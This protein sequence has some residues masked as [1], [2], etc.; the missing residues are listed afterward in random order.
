M[1]YIY[2]K[3]TPPKHFYILDI[4]RG[5]AA[6]S[7]VLWHWQHFYFIKTELANGFLTQ[8]QPLYHLF[9]VFYRDGL[10]AVDFFFSLSGFI[11]FYLYQNKISEQ[12]ITTRNFAIL[13]FSRLYPLHF[14]TLIIVMILQNYA[15]THTGHYHVY[16]YNDSYHFILNL[17][18][19]QTWGFE[20][21]NSFNSPS[22]SVSIEVFLYCLFFLLCRF[23]LI[24]K[25][26]VWLLILAGYILYFYIDPISRGIFS[27]FLGGAVYY[28]YL[29]LLNKKSIKSYFRILAAI[30]ILSVIVIPLEIH[31]GF[32]ENFSLNF[33]HLF[34]INDKVDHYLYRGII[35]YL[36]PFLVKGF[37]FPAVILFLALFETLKG[38]FGKRL[39]F[40]GHISFSAYL[41]HFPL[42][43]LL[44]V[45]CDQYK[46]NQRVLADSPITLL[47]F[48]LVLIGISL[49]SFKYLEMPM[50]VYLRK[51]LTSKEL[52]HKSLVVA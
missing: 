14:V 12:K 32:L 31:S 39:A 45:I 17:F 52:D 8:R 23:K 48:Y 1:E 30:C 10:L 22:W 28:I 24:N 36:N 20:A 38:A 43:L 15:Y 9:F 16:P 2:H 26:T 46:L 27:F 40:I 7:V 33:V 19:I 3:L 35:A 37:I 18:F 21:G 11:F 42:Q 5:F 4:V 25:V 34:L 29:Q 13:R 41:I 6:L 47:V 49:L 44:M 51:K 50:Q